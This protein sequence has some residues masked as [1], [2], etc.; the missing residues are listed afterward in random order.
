MLQLSMTYNPIANAKRRYWILERRLKRL[1]AY[2]R[3][4][5]EYENGMAARMYINTDPRVS[6]AGKLRGIIRSEQREIEKVVH[7]NGYNLA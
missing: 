1:S 7:S 2:T 5:I 6:K 4:R 3:T